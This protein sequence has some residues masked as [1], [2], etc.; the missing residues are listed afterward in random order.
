[1]SG[2]PSAEEYCVYLATQIEELQQQLARSYNAFNN[3]E[4]RILMI[5]RSIVGIKHRLDGEEYDESK[6]VWWN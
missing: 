6:G 4:G 2:R 5:E 3:L 1:L